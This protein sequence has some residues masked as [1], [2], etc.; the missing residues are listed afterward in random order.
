MAIKQELSPVTPQ[1]Q[2]LKARPDNWRKQLW[3]KGRNMTV[4]HLIYSMR[5][6]NQLDDPE[7]AARNFDLSVEQ[8]KEALDYY[9]VNRHIIEADVD[10]EKRWLV[11]RG[12]L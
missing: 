3:L 8:I 7:R 11:E 5:A 6:S 12:L 2:Y 4:G 9:R 1:Y 10:E